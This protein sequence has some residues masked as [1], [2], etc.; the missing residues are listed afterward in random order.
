MSK[1]L[2]TIPHIYNF[3]QFIGWLSRIT[4]GK[5]IITYHIIFEY[6]TE[7]IRE[8]I[9]NNHGK[10]FYELFFIVFPSFNRFLRI[11]RSQFRAKKDKQPLPIQFYF[12]LCQ[13][14][15]FKGTKFYLLIFLRKILEQRPFRT[16][17]KIVAICE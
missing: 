10:A 9:L 5:I 7:D 8:S 4:E 14:R 3:S 2:Q 13:S 6:L 1:K 16:M 17:L 12:K 15:S 11:L